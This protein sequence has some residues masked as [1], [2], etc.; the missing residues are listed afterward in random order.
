V[1]RHLAL[2]LAVCVLASVAHAG[3][4][5]VIASCYDKKLEVAVPKTA[6]DIFIL[7]DQT[8]PLDMTLRQEV[9][10][11]VKPFLTGNHGF[12]IMTFSAFAQGRYVQVLTSGKIEGDIDAAARDEISKPLLA[13]FDACLKKQPQQSMQVVGEAL[14]SAFDG[15]SADLAK[16]DVMASFKAISAKVRNSSANEKTVLIVSDMLENSSVSSFYTDKG[17]S[18]RK[19]DPGKEMTL[20][21]D[22]NLLADF[23]GAKVYVIGTGILP[24][25]AAKTR[26]YRDPK[27]MQ[28]LASFWK[29][30]FDKSNARLM[31]LGQPALLSPIR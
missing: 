20:A 26:K 30:Y 8:T 12:A 22:N 25:D 19:I 10:D 4:E 21:R 7:I 31:E 24:D 9:A 6:T 18:V 16:S 23:G 11:N 15:I 5:D 2:G 13:K 27:T 14:R 29:T 1:I 3:S 28:A 17:A